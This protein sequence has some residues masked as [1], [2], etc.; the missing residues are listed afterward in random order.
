MRTV[1][2]LIIAKRTYI[3][4]GELRL[5]RAKQSHSLQLTIE[6]AARVGIPIGLIDI[7]YGNNAL[8]HH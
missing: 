5:R 4:V 7:Y 8:T 1:E 6:R 2:S 3:T